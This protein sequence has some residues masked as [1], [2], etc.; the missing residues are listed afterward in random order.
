MT[1]I[2][3][4]HK[5][6]ENIK[7][8]KKVNKTMELISIAKVGKFKSIVKLYKNYHEK[9]SDVI[10]RIAKNNVSYIEYIKKN[11]NVNPSKRI[12]IIFIGSERGLCGNLNTNLYKKLFDQKIFFNNNKFK[13][14][15]VGKKIHN[16]F[17]NLDN[18]FYKYFFF[19]CSKPCKLNDY[20]DL[21]DSILKDFIENRINSIYIYYNEYFNIFKKNPIFK[22][23]FPIDKKILNKKNIINYL[24]EFHNKKENISDIFIDY[25]KNTIYYATLEN[26]LCE[27]ALRMITM[28]NAN[29][30]STKLINDLSF[31]YN[32]ER[33]SK[34]TQEIAEIVNGTSH[35]NN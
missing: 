1:K 13:F 2:R 15:L 24:Y 31:L 19:S 9:Y 20:N 11:N 34:I 10:Y 33:Q 32:K 25:I 22:K 23:I 27:H 21:Y 35:I 3:I 28:K 5:K 17:K 26:Q 8:I 7:K 16:L 6:I 29:E 4:I 30:N 18:K 12:G 14:Y